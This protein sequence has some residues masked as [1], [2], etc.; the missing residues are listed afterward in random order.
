MNDEIE[1]LL[2]PIRD[3]IESLREEAQQMVDDH[4]Q[5]YM[6]ENKKRADFK[7][8]SR[9]FPRIG[10][11]KNGFAIEW[12]RIVRWLKDDQKRW[13]KVTRYIARGRSYRTKLDAYAKP[14]ETERLRAFE[15]RAEMIRR[16]TTWLTD[17]IEGGDRLNK[18]RQSRGEEA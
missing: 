7:D 14:W 9:L 10:S 1:A 8:K 4:W 15:D 12:Y 16:E 11:N 18:L 3:R 13:K 2:A 17:F 5:F 6:D